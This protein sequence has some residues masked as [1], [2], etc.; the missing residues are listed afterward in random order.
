MEILLIQMLRED[1]MTRGAGF[2]TH[3]YAETV[4][5]MTSRLQHIIETLEMAMGKKKNRGR[6][7]G[8]GKGWQRQR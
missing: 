1:F 5:L 6:R 4:D 7:Q 3:Y 8:Q 2:V